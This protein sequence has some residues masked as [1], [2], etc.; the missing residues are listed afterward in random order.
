[1]PHFKHGRGR[2]AP[3]TAT[4]ARGRYPRTV[5][6]GHLPPRG[7]RELRIRIGDDGFIRWFEATRVRAPAS[8]PERGER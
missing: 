3:V 7:Q 5:A 4:G 2:A 1:M 8:E 6:E